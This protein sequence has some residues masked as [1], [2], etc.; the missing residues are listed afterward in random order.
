MI[1]KLLHVNLV[2]YD[3]IGPSLL[4]TLRW[5]TVS[6]LDDEVRLRTYC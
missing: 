1:P 3:D 4:P 5:P 6:S 2:F